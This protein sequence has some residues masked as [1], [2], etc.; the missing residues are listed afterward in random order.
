MFI[1]LY[2]LQNKC[3]K[4]TMILYEALVDRRTQTASNPNKPT[5]QIL[6]G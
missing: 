2:I 4:Y 5:D 1:R 3:M 6:L